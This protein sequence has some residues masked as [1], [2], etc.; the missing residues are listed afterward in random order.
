MWPTFGS[1]GIRVRLSR[2]PANDVPEELRGEVVRIIE[3]FAYSVRYGTPLY[4]AETDS[5]ER[6]TIRGTWVEGA[7]GPS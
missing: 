6:L 5:G 2:D 7:V 3:R 1:E 4:T